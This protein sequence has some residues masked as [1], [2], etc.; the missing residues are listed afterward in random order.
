MFLRLLLTLFLLPL[1]AMDLAAQVP[2]VSP[3]PTVDTSLFAQKSGVQKDFLRLSEV[4]GGLSVL[5]S[6]CVPETLT[7]AT[8]S[9]VLSAPVLSEKKPILAE[10]WY[11]SMKELLETDAFQRGDTAQHTQLKAR[12]IELYNTTAQT[13]AFLHKA[14]LPR[15]RALMH[16]YLLEGEKLTQKITRLY[17]R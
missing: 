9:P 17:I 3:K 11:V 7:E 4:L 10:S 2:P 14:C 15:S 6:L 16:L 5:S 1:Y 13:I 12:M 8:E